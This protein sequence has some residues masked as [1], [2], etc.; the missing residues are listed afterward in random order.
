MTTRIH[1]MM[2]HLV[3]SA[4]AA[5]LV[6]APALRAQDDDMP[7]GDVD[8]IEKPKPRKKPRRERKEEPKRE[9]QK[10]EEPKREEPKREEPRKEPPKREAPPKDVPSDDDDILTDGSSAVKIAPR[11][12]KAEPPPPPP[13]PEDTGKSRVLQAI[14]DGPAPEVVDDDVPARPIITDDVEDDVP[15]RP[16]ISDAD[17]APR[18]RAVIAPV[19]EDGDG[20]DIDT[21]VSDTAPE[22]PTYDED[23]GDSTWVIVGA[24]TGG[25]LLLAGAGVGGFFV[26]DALTPKTGTITVTPR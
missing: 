6:A 22:R 11:E 2:K 14:E 24:A 19:A 3:A 20:D 7:D 25:L 8:I 16:I 23:S 17:E 26:V 4:C 1:T 9:E 13:P 5:L 12:E 10:R 21:K 15:A 18:E